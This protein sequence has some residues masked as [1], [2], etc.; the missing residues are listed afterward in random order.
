MTT[1]KTFKRRI[2][3]R[4]EKTGESFTAARAQL[5]A[6]ADRNGTTAPSS[7][8]PA[9][10]A[11]PNTPQP[12]PAVQMPVSEAA[13]VKA[14]GHGWDHWLGLLDAWGAESHSHT[15]IAR[16]AH[17][18][19]GVPNWWSQGVTVGFE[20]ARGLRG[21]Y[22]RMGGGGF[23]VNASFTVNAPIERV[24]SAFL[25]E[26]ERSRWL[27]AGSIR[28]RSPRPNKGGTFDFVEP[29]SRVMA[30]FT[31]KGPAKTQAGVEHSR[32]PDAESVESVRAFWRE[33]FA[34]LK[35]RLES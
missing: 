4:A 7:A 14:T 35:E 12:P 20:R 28:L 17:E 27:P 11:P 22:E 1:Q 25:D 16:Y 24:S 13:L 3:A 30:W 15:E 2:R 18:E 8:E 33:R 29:S 32:L 10:P 23:S 9:P 5:L 34:E 26:S 6:R 31:S 19:L 21:L